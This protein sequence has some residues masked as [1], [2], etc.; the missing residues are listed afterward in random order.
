[1]LRLRYLLLIC[2]TLILIVIPLYAQDGSRPLVIFITDRTLGSGS[3]FDNSATGLSRLANIF[4]SLGAEVT[5]GTLNQPLPSAAKVV[6]LIQPRR[7]LTLIEI[8]RLWIHLARGGHLL[9]ALDPSGYNRVFTETTNSPLL[10]LLTSDYGIEFL[11]GL[12]AGPWATD[13]SVERLSGTLVQGVADPVLHPVVRPLFEYML[14]V[15]AWGARPMAITPFGVDYLALPLAH[16]RSAYAETDRNFFRGRASLGFDSGSDLQGALNI[17]GFGLNLKGGRVAA[18]GDSEIFQNDFGLAQNPE[19]GAPRYPGNSIMAERIAAWLLELPAES[20]PALPSGYTWI[21]VDGSSADW[22]A[23]DLPESLAV[24]EGEIQRV[25]AV[26][27]DAYLYLLVETA[28]AADPELRLDIEF[29]SERGA[30]RIHAVDGQIFSGEEP[31][32]LIAD[33]LFRG[34]E[35]LELRLPLRVTGS[36][37]Q[38]R[39]V[40]LSSAEAAPDCAGQPP[41]AQLLNSAAPADLA[42]GGALPV[43]RVTTLNNSAV[44]RAGPGVAYRRIASFEDGHFLYAVGRNTDTTWIQVQNAGYTGWIAEFLLARTFDFAQLPVIEMP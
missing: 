3:N 26:Y 42:Q 41:Q 34:G 35:A 19:S 18:F 7:Q 30:L 17:G 23:L 13:A 20:W 16:T 14:P 21:A 31:P 10:S 4:T 36:P 28:R 24:G 12:L 39:S 25:R 32:Q 27:D 43:V 44:M 5:N 9:L 40:C 15:Y 33:G 11:D 8:V 29:A 38:I 22:Q 1:M 2:V 6:V 37:P